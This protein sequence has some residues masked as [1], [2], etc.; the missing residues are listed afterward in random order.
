MTLDLPTEG[1]ERKRARNESR[2][3]TDEVDVD[4]KISKRLKV[5]EIFA[6]CERP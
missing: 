4:A 3:L 2:W 1:L 5:V 6:S